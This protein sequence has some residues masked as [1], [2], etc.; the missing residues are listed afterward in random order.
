MEERIRQVMDFLGLSQQD[1]AQKLGISPA[2][3]SNIFNGRSKPTNN[4]VQ[5]I[6]RAFPKINTNWLMFGEGVMLDDGGSDLQNPDIRPPHQISVS[7]KIH[8]A[9]EVTDRKKEWREWNFLPPCQM[10][11]AE[12]KIRKGKQRRKS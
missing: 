8:R 2:S 9:K 7:R 1:F 5:A 3:L 12:L 11:Q 4:H 6:H 10:L